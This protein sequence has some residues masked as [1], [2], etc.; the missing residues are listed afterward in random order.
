MKKLTSACVVA[1]AVSS[2]A[3][4]ADCPDN[5]GLIDNTLV[6][7]GMIVNKVICGTGVGVS[8]GDLWAEETHGDGTL[9]ERAQGSDPVDPRKEVGT[10]AVTHLFTP[11][12]GNANDG[13][14]LRFTYPTSGSFDFVIYDTGASLIMCPGVDTPTQVQFTLIDPIPIESV[15]ACGYTFQP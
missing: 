4:F 14:G 6:L 3:S 1:L 8:A 5:A 10:W 9:H 7:G 2:P 12:S 15:N 11:I 13:F